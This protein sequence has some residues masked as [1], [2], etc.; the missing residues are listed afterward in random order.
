M[1][2]DLKGRPLS[3]TEIAK[4]VGENWQNL[5]AHER[6]P[7]EQ[8]AFAAKEKYNAE[9][10]EYKKTEQ[11]KE[12]SQYLLDFKARQSHQQ[13]GKQSSSQGAYQYS[14]STAVRPKWSAVN[15]PEA[16]SLT[17]YVGSRCRYRQKAKT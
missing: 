2:E 5:A 15:T 3:F 1:R 11:Y 7:Y 16:L 4:L 9:L 14:L 17:S 13:Q 12:Y 10:V 6:E 8:Q